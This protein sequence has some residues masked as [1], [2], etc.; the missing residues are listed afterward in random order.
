MNKLTTGTHA[1]MKHIKIY[2]TTSEEINIHVVIH[3][4]VSQIFIDPSIYKV[5]S[6]ATVYNI[7]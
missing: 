2:G 7:I 3:N 5:E 6:R 1:N 4:T